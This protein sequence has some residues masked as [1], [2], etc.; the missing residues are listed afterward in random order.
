MTDHD[1]ALERRLQELAQ[2]IATPD[3]P[4]AADVARGRRRLVRG[5]L[6]AGGGALAVLAVVAVGLSIVPGGDAAGPTPELGG[7]SGVP[8]PSAPTTSS[9]VPTP[10][11]S[12]LSA[13]DAVAL[14]RGRTNDH[15][16]LASW[17]RALAEHLDPGWDHLVEYTKRNGN[18]QSS[19]DAS[20]QVSSL[21]SKYGWRNTGESGLGMLQLTVSSGWTGLYWL[22]GYTGQGDEAW[23]C[24]DLAPPA[25]AVSAQVAQ[26]EGITEVAVERA[27]GHV[28]VLA[29]DALFGN[30]STVPVSGIDLSAR[31]LAEA[32][33][34]P[35]I[36]LPGG[37]SPSVPELGTD[38]VRTVLLETLGGASFQEQH[39][40]NEHDVWLTGRWLVDGRD[41]GE[42]SVDAF[43]SDA[44]GTTCV[45]GQFAR[46]EDLVVEGVEVVVG[47]VK[48]KWGGGWQVWHTGPSY[49]V[50]VVYDGDALIP[51]QAAV[52]VADPRL[53][54]K[55]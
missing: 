30:N 39:G 33:A 10:S 3:T 37:A 8:T 11:P 45:R 7:A 21:G 54:P 15:E 23:D 28:V 50:R 16:L 47:H 13:P 40:G 42:L 49:E 51:R 9:A 2:G 55:S 32:A 27:D 26:H 36:G 43:R 18:Q 29:V 20:G 48:E 14:V 4:V 53:Q 44:G 38:A 24:R 35:R 12:E 41:T 46:C 22:C 17:Q 5:R 1:P 25:G 34:D 52:V 31:S 19:T 6:A